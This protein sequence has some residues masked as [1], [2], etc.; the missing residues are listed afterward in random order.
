[1]IFELSAVAERIRGL[2][3][4]LDISVEEM[5]CCTDTSVKEYEEFEAGQRDFTFSFLF[6]CAQ[7]FGVD[8]TDLL[9]GDMPKLSTYTV[10]RK[11]EGLP[12]ERRQGFTY[13]NLAYLF[14]GRVA[15]PFYVTAPYREDEQQK[16]IMLSTHEGHEFDYVLKGSMKFVIGN[17]VEVLSEGDSVYYAS[18]NP[19]GMIAVGGQACEFLSMILKDEDMKK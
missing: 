4:V 11:G 14:K 3:D 17:H 16:P 12:I 6:K 19:H 2:R 9:T 7:R 1:M 13:Q 5:A 18:N 15:E 10:C 8:M